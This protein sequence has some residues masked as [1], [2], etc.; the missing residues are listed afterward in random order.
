MEAQHA[1][2]RCANKMPTFVLNLELLAMASSGVQRAR[3]KHL[4]ASMK[5]PR[6]M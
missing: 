4:T 1:R 5:T 2:T 6:P 3:G